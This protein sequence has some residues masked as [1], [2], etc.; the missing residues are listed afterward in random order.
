MPKGNGISGH[1]G[2]ITKEDFV[3]GDEKTQPALLFDIMDF[4]NTKLN[5]QP[6][7]C[8]NQSEKCSEDF[9]TKGSLK[10]WAAG[11]IIMLLTANKIP[12][13]DVITS[14]FVR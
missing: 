1:I 8:K 13:G 10:L 12:W 9:V 5:K 7:K 11:I 14:L 3:D 6:E 2:P 4:I